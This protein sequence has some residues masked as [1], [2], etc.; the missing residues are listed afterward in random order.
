[1]DSATFNRYSAKREAISSG[2][3]SIL[4]ASK[5][6]RRNIDPQK[7]F[8]IV[9]TTKGR[10]L[11]CGDNYST[12]KSFLPSVHAEGKAL[13]N[14]IIKVRAERGSRYSRKL[15][16]DIIVARTTGGN[17]RP[18]SECAGNIYNN[19]HFTVRRVIYS[20]PSSDTGDG[21]SNIRPGSLYENRYQHISKFN[22]RRMGYVDKET[23]TLYN[24]FN[25]DAPINGESP[26]GRIPNYIDDPFTNTVTN[27]SDTCNEHEH[28]HGDD[29][30]EEDDADDEDG[31]T[32]QL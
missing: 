16:V 19:P 21:Y 14:A 25:P 29:L 28:N 13:S 3:R 10:I 27:N 5:K 11:A 23:D 17:S 24:P 2:P 20:D 15:K 8:C 1:M 32:P 7:H 9:Q 6:T 26:T 31:E 12:V 18:C 30:D 4:A 22:L